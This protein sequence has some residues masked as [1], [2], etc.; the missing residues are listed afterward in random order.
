MQWFP[1]LTD[2]LMVALGVWL[3]RLSWISTSLPRQA[4]R[5]FR[6][7]VVMLG[8]SVILMGI[9]GLVQAR[10]SGPVWGAAMLLLAVGLLAMVGALVVGVRSRNQSSG[11]G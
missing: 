8:A 7:A 2:A 1:V 6:L 11:A 10:T 3:L 9:V 4:V 5:V